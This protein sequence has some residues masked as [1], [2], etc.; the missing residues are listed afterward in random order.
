MKNHI[1]ILLIFLLIIPSFSGAQISVK[2]NADTTVV[3]EG[4]PLQ[5]NDLS[6]GFNVYKW[7][8]NF[9]DDST[10]VLQ[11]PVHAYS[12]SGTYTVTLTASSIYTDDTS[13]ATVSKT[14]YIIVR[15]IPAPDFTYTDTMFLPSYLYYF[16]GSVSNDD[17]VLP[18]SYYWNFDQLQFV[19]GDTVEI[20]TFP[21]EGDFPVS[22]IVESGAGCTDTVTKIVSVKDVLEAPNIFSPNGDG[23]NDVFLVKS[24]GVNEFVLEVFNRWGA[25]IYSLTAKRLQ[26]DGRSSSGVILPPGT[27][28][29]HVTSP[30]VKGYNKAGVILLVK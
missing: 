1:L 5:F 4:Y 20:H 2:F 21:K 19:G 28:Y 24:N 12:T 16:K 10:S 11:N 7:L 29:Y 23:Q 17:L 25:I 14:N 22:L 8:W 13:T 3:C 18:F 26:W 6:T 27:Y 30:D 15:K 9:G